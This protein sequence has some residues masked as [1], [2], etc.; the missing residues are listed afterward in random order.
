MRLVRQNHGAAV[1]RAVWLPFEQV[2][3]WVARTREVRPHLDHG[4][5]QRFIGT[6]A[7][8]DGFIEIAE[9]IGKLN[10]MTGA[11]E[12]HDGRLCPEI[13]VR[14]AAVVGVELCLR[15]RGQT[16]HDLGI[17]RRHTPDAVTALFRHELL[18][19]LFVLF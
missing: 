13:H 17:K 6:F 18:H 2:G 8:I 14:P 9:H 16:E 12:P 11:A 10:R 7:R 5:G 1:F 3:G 4:I 15:D 19:T